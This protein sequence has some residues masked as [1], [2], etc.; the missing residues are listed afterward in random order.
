MQVQIKFVANGC[1]TLLGN[2]AA[3]DVAR[4]PVDLANHLVNEA[5]CARYVE[6]PV[7]PPPAHRQVRKARA[8][9]LNSE[10]ES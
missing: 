5:G 2:F 3:G 4:V 1:C 8:K 9:S 6:Q 7:Q 10:I